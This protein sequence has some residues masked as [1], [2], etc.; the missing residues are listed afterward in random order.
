MKS[1]VFIALLSLMMIGCDTNHPEPLTIELKPALYEE[2][3]FKKEFVYNSTNQLIQ[4]R[5][6]STFTNGG[7]MTSTQ[8]FSYLSNGKLAQTTS[9]TGFKFVYGYNGDKIIRTDEYV[10]DAWSKYHAFTYDTHGRLTEQITYQNIPDEGGIIPTSKDTFQ[11][12]ANG[13]L[14]VM[15]MYYYTSYGAE[16]KL[17]T[18][19]ISSDYDDKLNTEDYFD[20]NV[21]NPYVNL[22]KNNPG[23]LITQNAAGNVTSTEVFTYQYHPMG[24]ATSK[25]TQVTW[26]H[27]GTG[28]YTTTFKF[29]E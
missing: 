18:T 2:E 27:G 29:R 24:Y 5:L 10:N 19:F 22:R 14:E 25:T 4:I 9:D 16:A 20:V 13:N 6:I 3:D 1:I 7:T 23:K 12:D 26:Q 15:N 11:Y 21:F 8:D 28:T 17:L